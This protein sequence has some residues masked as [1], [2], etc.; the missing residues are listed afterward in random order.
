MQF[1]TI[2]GSDIR[3]RGKLEFR[4]NLQINGQFRGKIQT[5]G[6]LTI[7]S[8]ASVEADI[9]SK[10]VTI[11]GKL[12]GNIDA[13]GQILLRKNAALTGDIRSPDL[14]IESGSRFNGNCLMEES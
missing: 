12:I 11:E 4:K 2:L 3:F 8:D 7:G 5:N 9:E 13:S 14:Q 1:D 10:T 6:H